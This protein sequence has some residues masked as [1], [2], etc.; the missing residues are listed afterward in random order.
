MGAP[1]GLLE[2]L[3]RRFP[4]AGSI[5]PKASA[6]GAGKIGRNECCPCGSGKKYKHCHGSGD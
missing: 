2:G 5:P 1:P 3:A 4:R 6:A